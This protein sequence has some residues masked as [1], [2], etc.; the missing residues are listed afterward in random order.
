MLEFARKKYAASDE[1]DWETT[2]VAFW[3]QQVGPWAQLLSGRFP[4]AVEMSTE[5]REA[6]GIFMQQVA[7]TLLTHTQANWLVV[8]AQLYADGWC[9]GY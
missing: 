9:G 5:Q 7:K 1:H 6:F 4:D 2:W 8:I 3:R